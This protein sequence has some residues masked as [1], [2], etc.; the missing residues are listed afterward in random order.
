MCDHIRS[1]ND[2][3]ILDIWS[4]LADDQYGREMPNPN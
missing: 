2:T 3:K 1:L 4:R